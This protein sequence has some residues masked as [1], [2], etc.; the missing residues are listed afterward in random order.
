MTGDPGAPQQRERLP[1]AYWTLVLTYLAVAMN[2]TVAS[3]ALPSISVDL[4]PSATELTWILNA[5][6][7]AA[8]ALVLFGGAWG[9]R[10]GRRR[11]LRAGLIVFLVAA[12]LSSVAWDATQLIALR[13]LSGVGSAMVMPAALALVFDV[14]PEPSRRTAIGIIAATQAVGSLIGPILAGV[15][16]VFASW[17]AAFAIVAPVLVIA[18]V[19]TVKLPADPP[20]PVGGHRPMDAFGALLIGVVGFCLLYAAVSATEPVG[21]G[22]TTEIALVVAAVALVVLIWWE[23]RCA[24]PILVASVLRSRAFWLPTLV[25]FLGQMVLGGILFANTQYVQLVLGFSAF[26]AALFLVPALVGWVGSSATAGLTARRLGVRTVVAA[27]LLLAALGLFL[28]SRQG[29]QPVYIVLALALFLAGLMGVAPALMTHMAV[30][31]YPED[32]RTVGSGINS[33]ATRYGLAFGMA[34]FGAVIG[35]VFASRMTPAVSGLPTAD[36]EAA[37]SSLGG[38]LGV[39]ETLPGPAGSALADTARAAFTAGFSLTLTIAAAVLLA[40]AVLVALTL[41]TGTP[42]TTTGGSLE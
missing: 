17:G 41:R 14:V 37:V 42:A 6:P 29:Q 8:G 20:R 36:A 1:L 9:D 15:A 2:L 5:T 19:G 35:T 30:S 26:G 28:L 34:A 12:L 4:A 10:I 16:L 33:A 13:A 18:L 21:D 31:A 3:I 25:I 11:L 27:S 22:G 23:R 24:H 40:V 38:A 7:M 39:A 32:R